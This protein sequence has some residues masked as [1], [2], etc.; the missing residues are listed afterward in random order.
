MICNVE[1]EAEVKKEYKASVNQILYQI[2]RADETKELQ[3]KTLVDKAIQQEHIEARYNDLISHAR[4]G[5]DLANQIHE[6]D[7]LTPRWIAES[8]RLIARVIETIQEDRSSSS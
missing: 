7:V 1:G 4:I 6:G 5:I 2:K 3:E 8:Q